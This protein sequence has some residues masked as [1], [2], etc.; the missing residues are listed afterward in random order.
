VSSS[1]CCRPRSSAASSSRRGPSRKRSSWAR[2]RA[3]ATSI[4]APMA[5]RDASP[6][7]HHRL[8]ETRRRSGSEAPTGRQRT[9]RRSR[10]A[11]SP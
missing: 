8:V 4:A 11:G 1:A 5:A 6:W 3:L 10:R 9:P 2:A 7:L